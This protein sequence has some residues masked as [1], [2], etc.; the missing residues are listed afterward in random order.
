MNKV[1]R[2]VLWT[3]NIGGLSRGPD[4]PRS[5]QGSREILRDGP[6]RLCKTCIQKC[7]AV[8]TSMPIKL[9]SQ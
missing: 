7:P 9:N 1:K 6:D 5:G 8:A 2:L 4:T 3:Q